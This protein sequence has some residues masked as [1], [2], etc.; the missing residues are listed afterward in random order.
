MGESEGDLVLL[1]VERN[2]DSSCFHYSEELLVMSNGRT[3]W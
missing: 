3:H 1:F 2:K